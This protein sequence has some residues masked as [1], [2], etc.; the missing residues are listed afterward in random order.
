LQQLTVDTLSADRRADKYFGGFIKQRIEGAQSVINRRI[1]VPGGV[2]TLHGASTGKWTFAFGEP[3]GTR[4]VTDQAGKFAQG[5]DYQ[6]FGEVR[7]PTDATAGMTNYEN[8]QFNGGDLLAAFG[9]VNLGARVYDPVVGRFLSR[10]AVI[11]GNPYGFA[12]NDP[13]NRIDPTGLFPAS[14]GGPGGGETGI[15]LHPPA[16][17]DPFPAATAYTDSL[18]M[19]GAPSTGG[20]DADW[21]QYD[22]SEPYGVADDPIKAG[23]ANP[24]NVLAL[25]SPASGPPRVIRWGGRDIQLSD[26]PAWR[27]L[28]LDAARNNYPL[29]ISPERAFLQAPAKILNRIA[30]SIGGFITWFSGAEDGICDGNGNCAGGLGRGSVEPY[31]SGGVKGAIIVGTV[32]V[33]VLG[34]AD[35]AAALA[36]GITLIPTESGGVILSI[37]SVYDATLY[38]AIGRTVAQG[39][40]FVDGHGLAI[41]GRLTG[42][43]AETTVEA[44][45]SAVTYA[46]GYLRTQGIVANQVTLSVCGSSCVGGLAEAVRASSGLPTIGSR[47]VT[48][49]LETLGRD[50]VTYH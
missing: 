25:A 31:V 6:P 3:R 42:L 50:G 2:A 22:A 35:G 30:H 32:L 41:A 44:V 12:N 43:P 14:V 7:N 20:M 23:F 38:Q 39:E 40:I 9:V 10:D 47:G 27:A 28:Q 11:G 13:I 16:Y 26:S 46:Q 8:Q 36:E 33:P 29:P 37:G 45:Q 24:G 18:P 4:F 34:A 19:G 5:I 17:M 15:L 48:S 1:P 21:Q 49:V